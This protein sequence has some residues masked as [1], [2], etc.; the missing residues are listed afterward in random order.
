MTQLAVLLLAL[1]TP[2]VDQGTTDAAK[3]AA[4]ARVTITAEL[5][6][7]H[8][9]FGEGDHCAVCL[10]VDDQTPVV[11]EGKAAQQFEEARLSKK[12]LVAE[13]TLSVDKDKRLVLTSDNA[14]L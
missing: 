7:L 14:H 2:A 4:P 10:K 1:T 3:T 9:T 6:C 8:C 12:V 5:A 11:L 13:G